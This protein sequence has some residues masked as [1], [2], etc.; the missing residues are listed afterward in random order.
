MFDIPVLR[1]VGTGDKNATKPLQNLSETSDHNLTNS[2][3][4]VPATSQEHEVSQDLPSV[5]SLPP[6]GLM[7]F[8]EDDPSQEDNSLPTSSEIFPAGREN[9]SDD[10]LIAGSLSEIENTWDSIA[11]QDGSSLLQHSKSNSVDSAAS[12][13]NM[14]PPSDRKGSAGIE[15]TPGELDFITED[16]TTGDKAMEWYRH[17]GVGGNGESDYSL[18][19]ERGQ[20]LQSSSK[21]DPSL[22]L[23]PTVAEGNPRLQ[24][25][26]LND[27][28][29]KHRTSSESRVHALGTG[30]SELAMAELDRFSPSRP[31]RSKSTELGNMRIRKKGN[32][33]LETLTRVGAT[34]EG[35]GAEFKRHRSDEHAHRIRHLT[36]EDLE[37][38]SDSA[39][40]LE[41]STN[42]MPG[43]HHRGA[44][45]TDPALSPLGPAHSG[46]DPQTTSEDSIGG[47]L[48]QGV[49]EGGVPNQQQQQPGVGGGGRQRKT[50]GRSYQSA[51]AKLH[52]ARSSS[53]TESVE[54]ETGMEPRPEMEPR[55]GGRIIRRAS[56][57]S[58]FGRRRRTHS[59]SPYL[60]ETPESPRASERPRLA[61]P[62]T[63]TP[64]PRPRS[65]TRPSLLVSEPEKKPIMQNSTGHIR[66][67]SFEQSAKQNHIDHAHSSHS[68]SSASPSYRS[69]NPDLLLQ[70]KRQRPVSAVDASFRHAGL[71]TPNKAHHCPPAEIQSSGR[72]S[73]TRSV[74]APKKIAIYH[75]RSANTP[76][77]QQIVTEVNIEE[78]IRASQQ[79]QSAAVVSPAM[80]CYSND[81]GVVMGGGE[82]VEVGGVGAKKWRK[83]NF[84]KQVCSVFPCVYRLCAQGYHRKGHLK[85][86]RIVQISAS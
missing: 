48:P 18:A 64:E 85:G 21:N 83:K 73:L 82:S 36:P 66:Q 19:Q 70:G 72:H 46:D 56:A 41:R 71:D 6:T 37:Q 62:V 35:R 8:S 42:S 9:S 61:T 24:E 79:S 16:P 45:A 22:P 27:L 2:N 53:R 40:W 76:Y 84:P 25:Q 67:H 74:E 15:F 69:N 26:R 78:A 32:K 20:N 75:T 7:P 38:K 80:R 81:S 11:V 55:H 65:P 43:A 28:A 54:S 33:S 86:S 29:L 31:V 49:N 10:I 51:R 30:N 68:Q 3:G 57:A 50:T 12:W 17:R 58:D 1:G 52:K 5:L 4:S 63:S 59:P 39:T 60:D 14:Y 34:S 77:G 47:S 44:T 23:P 13:R